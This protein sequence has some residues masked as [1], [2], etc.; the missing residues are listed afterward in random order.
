MCWFAEPEEELRVEPSE[1]GDDLACRLLM[2]ERSCS[3]LSRLIARSLGF[4][5]PGPVSDPAVLGDIGRKSSKDCPAKA[6]VW[7]YPF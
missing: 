1:L 3:S 2:V 4:I 6:G 7:P 5:N